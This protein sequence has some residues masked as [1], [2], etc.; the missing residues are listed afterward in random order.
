[1]LN[2]N[3]S[4]VETLLASI[5][6]GDELAFTRLFELYRD[7][8]YSIAIKITHSTIIADE[9][10]QDVF[11]K[12]WIRKDRLIEVQNFNAYLFVVTR[13]TVYKALK[14]IAKNYEITLLTERDQLVADSDSTD[15]V[16]EKEYNLLLQKAVDRLPN[17][18]KQVYQ[19]IKEK[20]LR[21]E[22]TAGLLHLSPETVKFHLTQAMKNIR[23]FCLLNLDVFIGLIIYN[24]V[25]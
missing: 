15:L 16:M 4:S 17:Q 5:A 9:I 19:Y 3:L 25:W 20:G 7:R 13:N 2:D 24:L 14:R 6:Q 22:E 23:A 10:V 11:L 8:I 18:Q 1:M 21:R 12:I